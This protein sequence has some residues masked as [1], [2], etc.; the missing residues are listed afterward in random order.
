MDEVMYCEKCGHVGHIVFSKKCK[1]CGTKMKLL[2]ENLKYKYHIFVED[3]AHDWLPDEKKCQLNV[4]KSHN[5]LRK[6]I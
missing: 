4:C 1:N 2:P 5:E 6:S 3:R